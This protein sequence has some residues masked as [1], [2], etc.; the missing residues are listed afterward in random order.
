VRKSSSTFTMPLTKRRFPSSVIALI[1]CGLALMIAASIRLK[2]IPLGGRS[3]GSRLDKLW[4]RD[5]NSVIAFRIGVVCILA[6]AWLAK[7]QKNIDDSNDPADDPIVRLDESAPS[8]RAP[9]SDKYN[10]T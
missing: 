2:D 7:A 3:G 1:L 10:P 9:G 6:A 4:Q 8:P 5:A